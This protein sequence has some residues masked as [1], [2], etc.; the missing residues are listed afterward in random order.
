MTTRR[1]ALFG[2]VVCLMVL[3]AAEGISRLL[4]KPPPPRQG[5]YPSIQ[6][7][8]DTVRQKASEPRHHLDGPLPGP[9]HDRVVMRVPLKTPGSVEFRGGGGAYKLLD[10]PRLPGGRRVLVFGGS[11]AWGPSFDYPKTFAA[12]VEQ[13]LRRELA[14][15]S[16]TVINLARPGWELNRHTKL[17][18]HVVKTLH[19]PP[20]AVI[21]LSGNNELLHVEQLHAVGVP[22]SPP[23]ALY[24]LLT[25]AFARRGW[26]KPP[27]G[28]DPNAFV[29]VQEEPFSPAQM[30]P[31]VWRPGRAVG[32]ASF[33]LPVRKAHL[34]RYRDNL[35]RITDQLNRRGTKV[36]LVP[37]PI[38]LHYMVGGMQKQPATFKKLGQQAYGELADRL[39]RALQAN[40]TAALEPLVKAYPDGALQRFALGQLY[41][42]AG[43]R[44]E[45][46]REHMAARGA[47]KGFLESLPAMNA[48]ARSLA[49]PGVLV[50]DT[51]AW[52]RDPR[53]VRK[54]ALT[55]FADSCHL[56]DDGHARLARMIVAALGRKLFRPAKSG[57]RPATAPPSPA[58]R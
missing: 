47:M 1:K 19:R 22:T 34:D 12:L 28:D 35:R 13:G 10:L 30:S 44:Q 17:L 57:E 42:A 43:R 51:R 4:W 58:P 26:L 50:M 36:V 49:G 52:Y 41:D 7:Y 37:P 5:T 55:M 46:V 33:W 23:L 6:I 48:I 27:E 54:T 9:T 18:L 45:A 40:T 14:D 20:A 29:T 31:R 56:T 8:T 39:Q 2:A 32:D 25:D 38:N 24:R 3:G 15:P 53:S 16:L 11:A 21:L